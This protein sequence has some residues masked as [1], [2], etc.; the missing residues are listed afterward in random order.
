MKNYVLY[1]VTPCGSLK[2]NQ[3]FEG[4]LRLHLQGQSANLACH[5]LLSVFLLGL[6]FNLE[7]EG[8]MFLRNVS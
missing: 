6:L 2:T 3:S 7:D 8:D 1:N 4:K 5:L